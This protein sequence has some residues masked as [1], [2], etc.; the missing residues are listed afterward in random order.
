M[1]TLQAP[2]HSRL[3]L[4]NLSNCRA[5]LAQQGLTPLE[6]DRVMRESILAHL[7]GQDTEALDGPA[8]SIGRVVESYDR[9]LANH[10][11][12]AGAL[13]AAID[14]CRPLRSSS[15]AVAHQR[16]LKDLDNPAWPAVAPEQA[17][18]AS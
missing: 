1:I 4:I 13:P 18:A 14:R 16:V 9:H 10:G 11:V 12:P 17:A 5:A 8:A 2:S 15:E 3:V 6:V 7:A